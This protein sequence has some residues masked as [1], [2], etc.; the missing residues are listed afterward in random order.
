MTALERYIL[1]SSALHFRLYAATEVIGT[2]VA[3]MPRAISV[4]QLAG[5]TGRSTRQVTKICRDLQRVA[6]LRP[7]PRLARR[8][9]WMLAGDPSGMTLD[10]IFRAVMEESPEHRVSVAPPS[11]SDSMQRDIDLFISQATMHVNDAIAKHLR[12]FTLDCFKT[13]SA[14]GDYYLSYD[15]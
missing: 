6:L 3:K 11:T 12:K 2:L 13:S 5:Y 8:E 10:D 15:R 7:D 1:G 14:R 9:G 4:E